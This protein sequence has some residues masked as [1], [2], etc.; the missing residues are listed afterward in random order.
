MGGYEG[1]NAYFP[2]TTYLNFTV[3]VSGPGRVDA[4]RLPL[5][6]HFNSVGI[7]HVTSL[8]VYT[9]LVIY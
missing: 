2:T 1:V 3:R 6:A 8:Q 5:F 4:R 9:V 7:F